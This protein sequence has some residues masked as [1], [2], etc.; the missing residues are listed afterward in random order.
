M[1]AK[2]SNFINGVTLVGVGVVLLVFFFTGR[3][4]Q[5]LHPQFRP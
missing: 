1:Q 4:D 3:V 5:Y 2:A